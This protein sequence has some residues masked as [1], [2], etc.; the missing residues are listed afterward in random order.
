MAKETREHAQFEFS[1]RQYS[2]FLFFISFLI[3][4]FTSAH[5]VTFEDSGLFISAIKALGLPQPPGY[6][7]YIL[8][9]HVFTYIPLGSL[10]YRIHLLSN[11][12]GAGTA[13]FLFLSLRQ[14]KF[15]K[16]SSF[17][18]ALAV[19]TGSTFWSQMIV[20][21]VYPLHIFIFS[22]L[23][24]LA[25]LIL[26]SYEPKK[27]NESHQNRLYILFGVVLGLGL[28][29]H[30]PLLVIGTPLILFFVW[31]IKKQ[32]FKQSWKWLG[33]SLL[34]AAVFYGFMMWRSQASPVISFLGPLDS[35]GDLMGYI[36][37]S[38]YR[39]IENKWDSTFVDKLYFL[40]DFIF[41][42]VWREWF[43]VGAVFVLGCYSAIKKYSRIQIV[44][45]LFG[46]LATPI[47]LPIQLPFEFNLLNQN[48]LKVFHLVSYFAA[49]LILPYGFEM[50]RA[51]RA[52]L[53]IPI[54]S[55]VVALTIIL[56]FIDNDLRTDHFAEDYGRVILSFIPPSDKIRP[57]VAGTDADVGPLSYIRY[58]LGERADLN[59]Y[60]QSGVFFDHRIFDPWM[61]KKSVRVEKTEN[62][63][64]DNEIVYSTKVLDILEARTNLPFV[65]NFNGLLYEI[66]L[67]T[68]PPLGADQVTLTLVKQALAD[69]IKNPHV[70]NWLYHREV[71]AARLCNFLILREPTGEPFEKIRSCKQVRARHLAKEKQFAA[72]DTIYKELIGSA[73]DMISAERHSLRYFQLINRLDQINTEPKSI[74]QK[75]ASF[76]EAIEYAAPALDDYKECDNNVVTVIKSVEGRVPLSENV[77]TKLARFAKCKAKPAAQPAGRNR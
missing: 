66:S 51:W 25:L 39:V 77:K 38:Y 45:L 47:V 60:T 14:L 18:S 24:Y 46:L 41:G 74:D 43:L 68:K 35:F 70:S 22:V 56:N 9:G 55:G 36:N 31:P 12:L 6:P 53:F 69:Y 26:K 75:Y 61:F 49:G 62:F 42:L 52:K 48:V 73:Q 13:V 54:A 4:A 20:A 16:W 59:L 64:K 5:S 10:A 71:I 19:V 3:F 50:I 29:N 58:G 33:S 30:W 32:I 65:F 27:P 2:A 28:A 17:F 76:S 37:R 67:Q 40:G 44:G 8:L 63:L 21:E 15:P 34:T 11:I 1:D 7:L 23:F 72:A 57:L